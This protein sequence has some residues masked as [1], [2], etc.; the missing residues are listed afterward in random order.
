M[1]K[2]LLVALLLSAVLAEETFLSASMR[3]STASDISG[4]FLLVEDTT[5]E[6]LCPTNITHT[7]W[8]VFESNPIVQHNT[9]IIDGDRCDSNNA[10]DGGKSLVFYSSSDYSFGLDPTSSDISPV[11]QELKDIMNS[12]GSNI[13]AWFSAR[14]YGEHFLFGFDDRLRICQG[15]TV[16]PAATTTF[17][18]RPFFSPISIKKL[19]TKL[20]TGAKW[21][22]IV[23]TYKGGSCVYSSVIE[24]MR[25]LAPEISG[26]PDGISGV[27]DG[28]SE[29]P[30]ESPGTKDL[31]MDAPLLI[32]EDEAELEESPE[33]SEEDVSGNNCF[34]ADAKVEV[35]GRGIVSMKELKIK[36]AVSVGGGA[37]E[38]V[39]GFTHRDESVKTKMVEIVTEKG[40]NIKMSEGH[41]IKTGGVWKEAGHLILDDE[42]ETE[43]GKERI[44]KLRFTK[45]EGLYNPQVI[46]GELIV[47]GVKVSCYT[48]AVSMGVAEALLSPLRALHSL[49][50]NGNWGFDKGAPKWVNSIISKK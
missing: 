17:L 11:P 6:K 26:E 45:T 18:L 3:E 49:G 2:F 24:T 14:D 38:E 27:S 40:K 7:S 4:T 30:E 8:R 13:N 29:V 37:Y 16:F 5:I 50:V 15:K 48:K 47:D 39:F 10:E 46:G 20:T 21:L 1:K 9:M 43:S 33:P 34:P 36:D 44:I 12:D 42:L 25:E 23:P 32:D 41:L 35:K 19:D 31:E 22:V 28:I